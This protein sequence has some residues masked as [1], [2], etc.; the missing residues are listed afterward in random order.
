VK[1]V[2]AADLTHAVP[3]DRRG[4]RSPADVLSRTIRG[5]LLRTAAKFFPGSSDREIARQL[6]TALS[7]YREGAWR[8]DRAEMRC[9]VRLRGSVSELFWQLLKAR[10]A[11]PGDRTIRAALAHNPFFI[12]HER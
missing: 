4:Q 5:H 9:P 1:A 10:D 2:H 8:R 6:R 7:R 11:I 12:A 3:L